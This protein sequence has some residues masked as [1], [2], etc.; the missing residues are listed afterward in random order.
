MWLFG[1]LLVAF[2]ITMMFRSDR[3]E[4]SPWAAC[5]ES[6]VSQMLFGECTPRRGFPPSPETPPGGRGTPRTEQ[7]LDREV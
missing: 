2:V 4:I 3:G 7:T 5:K 1:A 6:L